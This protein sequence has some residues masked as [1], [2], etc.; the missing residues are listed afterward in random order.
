MANDNRKLMLFDGLK[1]SILWDESTDAWTYAS[2]GPTTPMQNKYQMIPTLF[3]GVN[4]IANAVAKMPFKVYRAK[5]DKEVDNSQEYTN[6]V[7]FLPNPRQIF[8]IASM[9]LDLTGKCYLRPASNAAG[10]KKLLTYQNPTTITP[11][12][13]NG[14]LGGFERSENGQVKTLAIKE[15]VYM[16][17]PDPY[18]ELGPPTAYPAQAAF[19]ASSV[20]GNMDAYIALYFDRGAI[21]PVIVSVKGAPSPTERERM[22]SWFQKLMGGI[23]RGFTWKVFN[24]DTVD[25]KQIGDGLD[26]LQDT[27]LTAS[28]R[29]DVAHALG[30]PYAVLFS[31]AANNATAQADA[32][33]LYEQTI[34]PR[35]EFIA[36][37]LNDQLFIPAGYRLEFQPESLDIYQEDEASRAQSL[38]AYVNAGFPLLMACDILGVELTAEMRTQ[39]ESEEADKKKRAEEMEKIRN[40]PKPDE[41]KPDEQNN[42]TTTPPPQFVQQNDDQKAIDADLAKWKRKASKAFEKGNSANVPFESEII[43]LRVGE[44]ITCALKSADTAEAIENAFIIGDILPDLAVELHRANSLLERTIAGK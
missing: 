27:E 30:I 37:N 10:Y 12:I 18:V 29:Q 42:T 20:L 6:E 11:K 21:R 17:L 3:R 33:N 13:D 15:V 32:I 24:S 19:A 25:I 28:K 38:T 39:L 36:S 40:A 4:I 44:K 2:G 9:S 35:C 22:E 31:E 1:T 5:G 8:S 7:G 23:K 43:P 26:S 41:Q 16:W 34:E 14:I